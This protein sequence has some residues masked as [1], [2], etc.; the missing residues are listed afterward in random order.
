MILDIMRKFGC[1]EVDC[2]PKD[3]MFFCVVVSQYDKRNLKRVDEFTA[4]PYKPKDVA[5]KM[6]Y[7]GPDPGRYLV[8]CV[9][10]L[11]KAGILNYAQWKGSNYI[12]LSHVGLQFIKDTKQ[13]REQRFKREVMQKRNKFPMEML[14]EFIAYWTE[15]DQFGIMRF[16]IQ[17]RFK[18]PNR[19]A[20]WLRNAKAR[21]Q[22]QEQKLNR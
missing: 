9:K 11:D 5:E 6:G 14:V 18:I 4:L 21:G 2:K 8:G 22:Y 1:D 20:T 17:D 10:R 15:D 19:L 12:T 13:Q 16:E 3:V 7:T